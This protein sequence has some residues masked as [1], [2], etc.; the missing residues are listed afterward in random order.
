MFNQ[1]NQ[2]YVLFFHSILLCVLESIFYDLCLFRDSKKKFD[3]ERT[4]KRNLSNYLYY[5]ATTI[6]KIKFLFKF[7]K[8]LMYLVCNID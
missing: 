6:S 1:F 5:P 4:L 2:S 8:Q 3:P 7:I